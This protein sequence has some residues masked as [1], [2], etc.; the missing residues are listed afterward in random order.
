MLAK[1]ILLIDDDADLVATLKARLVASGYEVATAGDGREG[2]TQAIIF[3]P[4]L[5]IL[6]SLM[7]VM[8]GLQ[9]ME[10]Y[11]EDKSFH[12]IPVIVVSARAG[13]RDFFNDMPIKDF[14]VKPLN[15]DAFLNQVAKALGVSVAAGGSPAAAKRLLL[16]GVDK[17]VSHKVSEFF[18][19][20]KWE[21]L[22]AKNDAEAYAAAKSFAPDAILCQYWNPA[23][24]GSELNTKALADRL[25]QDHALSRIHFEVYCT[26]GP[27][28]EA[29]QLFPESQLI[30]YNESSDL[31]KELQKRFGIYNR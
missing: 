28:L 10:K 17:F 30:K 24:E 26:H 14:L 18:K 6:D 1:K 13:V 16:V 22:E 25:A 19:A 2:F 21:V 15:M 9:F 31:L 27:L 5:I 7:P 3:D 29:M 4:D 12:K 20:E 8:N 23:W 11:R